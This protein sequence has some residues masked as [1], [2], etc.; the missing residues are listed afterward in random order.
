MLRRLGSS[1]RDRPAD[2]TLR[3]AE[4]LAVSLGI[5]RVLD[6]TR[7]DRLG[8]PVYASVRP[9]GALLR[10]H[11]GKGL[12]PIEARVGALMEAIE[13]ASAE[14]SRSAWIEHELTVSTLAA[15]L[16]TGVAFGDLVPRIGEAV[17]PGRTMTSVACEDLASG[18]TVCLP[19]EL[20]FVPFA[21]QDPTALFG[22]TGNGLASGNSIA[23]ATLHAVFE[24]LE[25]DALAMAVLG[26]G[27]RRVAND[28]LPEPFARYAANWQASGI[29]LAV[30]TVPNACGLACFQAVLHEPTSTDV[31][32]ATG[33]GLHVDREIALARAICEAAQSR[34]SCIHGGRED[35]VTYYAKYTQV[36][37]ATRHERERAFV[38]KAFDSRDSLPFERVSHRANL[39][40]SCPEVLDRLLHHIVK[41]GFPAIYRH[42]FAVDLDRLHVVKVVIARCEGTE[43]EHGRI[44]PRLFAQAAAR[45]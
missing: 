25:R 15:Q 37:A 20:V 43:V 26:G 38:D 39:G 19:A 35:L 8:L 16:G 44:G 1:F 10:V 18:S 30:R 34:A 28:T 41:A 6:I 14:P 29:A 36:D 11:A 13:F 45:V 32:L 33:S 12:T 42:P 4:R 31:N 17:D 3:L 21:G 40:R 27:T 22:W 23:E 9:R 7:M 24:V 5:T 2:D